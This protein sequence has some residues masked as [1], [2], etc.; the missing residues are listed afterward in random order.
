MH[1]NLQQ[2]ARNSLAFTPS[3]IPLV[4]ERLHSHTL[5]PRMSP[6]EFRSTMSALGFEVAEDFA[7]HIGLPHRTVKSW[8][9]FGM[10]RDAAQLLLA[11]LHYRNRVQR[12]IGDI[13]GVTHIGLT[14]FFAEHKL[15]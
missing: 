6:D 12:A 7:D 1:T 5:K 10:A 2:F 8:A 11:L 13:E 4:L 9:R 15:P 14:D 3:D